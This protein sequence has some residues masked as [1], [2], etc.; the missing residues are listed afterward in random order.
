MTNIGLLGNP[1]TWA[2]NGLTYIPPEMQLPVPKNGSRMVR[3]ILKRQVDT[4]VPININ[5]SEI[6]WKI[7]SSSVVTLDFRRGC[8]YITVGVA[9]DAPWSAR[10]ANL[11]WN[12]FNRFRVEQHGQY[13]E[14]R[15]F[16]N[17]QE[18][19]IYWANALP[20]QFTT[21][22]EGLYGYGSQL[23]RNAKSATWEYA[24]PI[25]T[26][27][28]TKTVYP[29]FQLL[30]TMNN[31]Y[32]SSTLADVFMI[33]NVAD[34]REWIEVYGGAPAAVTG[35]TFTITKM[36]IEYEEITLESGNTGAFLSYWH[37]DD[38]MF[39]N[40][41]WETYLTSTYP[42]TQGVEQYINI[43]VRV[44][45]VSWI[46]ATVRVA[47]TL[48]DPTVYDKF[49]TWIGPEDARWPL[50]EYQ[51]ELNNNF[52]PD[53]PISLADPGDVQPYKKFLEL[54]GNYYSRTVHADVTAIGP[55]GFQNDKFMMAFDGNMYPFSQKMIGPVSTEKSS[56]YIV[57]RMKFDSAPAANLE[58]IVHTKY[59]R[60]WRFAAPAGTIVDW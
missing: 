19:F 55:D 10:I 8:V 59:W 56:K 51:W 41:F 1:S 32:V 43:D 12:M 53:R 36:E 42:L 9:V 25:P 30:K 60:K 26:D 11:A 57:L 58:L 17:W 39:P 47:N 15:Q 21:V 33:W 54:F 14:D 52:W 4:T 40:I 37:T 49:E 29:W 28:L 23:S 3:R 16:W 48:Q 38:N 46:V 31:S 27:A 22:G 35:L 50:S 13:V 5:N 7:P 44:K 2:A 6:R 45:S 20:N 18:T 24:L 34:P